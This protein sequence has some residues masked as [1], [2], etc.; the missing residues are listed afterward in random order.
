[1]RRILALQKLSSQVARP[2]PQGWSA[3]STNCSSNSNG[4]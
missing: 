3:I 1:M 2:A 4:C